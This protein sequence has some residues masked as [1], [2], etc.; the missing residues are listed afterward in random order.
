[1]KIKKRKKLENLKSDYSEIKHNQDVKKPFNSA[2]H[3]GGGLAPPPVVLPN[4]SS[5]SAG[6]PP[7]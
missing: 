7:S 1:M 6:M 3:P 2:A 4:T 5:C